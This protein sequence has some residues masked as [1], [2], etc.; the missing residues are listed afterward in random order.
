MSPNTNRRRFIKLAGTG[1]ALSLAGCNA[2]QSD[3]T[4]T[5]GT[6]TADDDGQA[7]GS[8]TV[9]LQI[10]LGQEAQR[11]LQQQQ[12]QIQSQVQSGDLSRSEAQSQIRSTQEELYGEAIASFESGVADDSNLTVEDS[13]EAFGVLLVSGTP[14]ALIDTLSMESV[15]SLYAESTF[16]QAKAQA[17]GQT[18][19]TPN[20]TTGTP[21]E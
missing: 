13:V 12:I 2:L 19:V 7:S 10:Q 6:A 11:Q 9:A 4:P 17:Q 1:T 5:D 16:E 20:E 15:G 21:A 8:A 14:E 3:G 18:Q